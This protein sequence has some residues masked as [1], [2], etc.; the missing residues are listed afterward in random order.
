MSAPARH[1]KLIP[2]EALDVLRPTENKKSANLS[3]L[4]QRDPGI[5]IASITF[6]MVTVYAT[7]R[8]NVFKGV[9][10]SEWPVYTLNKVFGV[11]SLVL[12]VIAV[13]RYR[14]GN[15]LPNGKIMYSAGLMAGIHILLSCF[16][17]KPSYYP[18]FF[19]S[20]KLTLIAGLSMLLGTIASVIFISGAVSKGDRPLRDKV[21]S[22]VMI[23]V[24][25]GLHT[26]FQGFQT[27]LVLST[28]PGFLPPITMLS[29]LASIVALACIIIPKRTHN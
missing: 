17:L 7:V 13:I 16:L 14:S 11:T 21:I 29:T 3:I 5:K 8:Y 19:T 18:K 23:C 27:W 26:F 6:S 25:T 9:A 24:L 20:D 28:W 22:L 10:W 1:K 4:P 2:E 12:L 15:T